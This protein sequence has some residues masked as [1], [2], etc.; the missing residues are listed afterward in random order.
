MVFGARFR[1]RRSRRQE[2][3][4]DVIALV[5]LLK[6]SALVALCYVPSGDACATIPVQRVF[7]P[8]AGLEPAARCL[9][10]SRSIQLSY[11]GLAR[12]NGSGRWRGGVAAAQGGR[13]IRRSRF[14]GMH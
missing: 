12:S 11:G 3:T 13:V 8:P 4:R 2:S 5:M 9:E 6:L 1:A 14:R 10:G 7:A